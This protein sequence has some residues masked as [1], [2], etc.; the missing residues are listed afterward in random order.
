MK[1]VVLALCATAFVVGSPTAAQTV[2]SARA[3]TPLTLERAL[4]EAERASPQIHASGWGVREAEAGRVVAGLRPNPTLNIDTE[5]IVGSGDYRA[6]REM[7]NTAA[8]SLPLEIGGQRA[9]RVALADTETRRASISERLAHADLRLALTRAFITATAAETQLTIAEDQRSVTAENLRVASR[10]VALGV[11]PPI[12]GERAQLQHLSAQSELAQA[13]TSE[14]M[15][16]IQLGHLLGRPVTEALDRQSIHAVAGQSL[17][18][19]GPRLT[20][21]IAGTL[22]LALAE[23]E[24]ARGNAQIRL[25]QSQRWQDV[26]VSAG[27]RRFENTGDV[28]FVV[29]VSLPLPVFNTGR[30]AVAQATYGRNRAEALRDVA[31]L[32]AQQAVDTAMAE[33]DRA[34][35]VMQSAEPRMRAAGEAARIARIGY[36]EG[37]MDQLVLLDAETALIQT[38]RAIIDARAQYLNAEAQLA[39]LLT[40]ATP[41][42]GNEMP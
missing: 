2:T 22:S 11:A 42:N 28:A 26:S 31:R 24:V 12:D 21:D 9:A 40:P 37:K 13:Q 16:R 39:H 8:V 23:A 19:Q 41:I 20:P 35:A 7:E 3:Q 25:A 32:E 6:L 4:E 33:R 27:A 34:Y 29:G 1:L 14:R 36:A 17:A 38:R 18:T 30:A 5:N 10:R 15:A